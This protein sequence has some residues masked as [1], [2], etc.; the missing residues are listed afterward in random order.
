V[1]FRSRGGDG[2]IREIEFLE[3]VELSL[4]TSRR[5]MRPYGLAGGEPGAAGRNLLRRKGQS[6]FEELP[7][8]T[9]VKV[10]PGDVLRVETPGGGGYGW[11]EARTPER[12]CVT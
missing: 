10:E 9:L 7:G 11:P 1:L 4:V 3:P 12:R 8:I 6:E 2:I 5:T